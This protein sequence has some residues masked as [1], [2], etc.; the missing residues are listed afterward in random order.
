M[1]ICAG[2]VIYTSP[3]KKIH[4]KNPKRTEVTIPSILMVGKIQLWLCNTR[5]IYGRQ[6]PVQ[7]LGTKKPHV[8]GVWLE[9]FPIWKYQDSSLITRAVAMSK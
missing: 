2:V 4:F 3:S 9:L 8:A 7:G 5:L 1:M 6:N